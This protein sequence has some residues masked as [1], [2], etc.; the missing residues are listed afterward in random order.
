[1]DEQSIS[2]LKSPGKRW[3]WF[4]TLYLI[5]LLGFAIAVGLLHLLI[6]H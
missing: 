5:S 4:I 2:K 1:M 6:P 3:M